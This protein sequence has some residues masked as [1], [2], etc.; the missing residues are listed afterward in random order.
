M[1][2]KGGGVLSSRPF[3]ASFSSA[4]EQR[5]GLITREREDVTRIHL[6]VVTSGIVRVPWR[7][8]TGVVGIGFG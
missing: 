1:Q 7:D 4:V 8:R 5:K 6:Q 3:P 2:G